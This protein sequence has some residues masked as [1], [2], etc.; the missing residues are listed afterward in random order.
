MVFANSG[1]KWMAVSI[2]RH[3]HHVRQKRFKSNLS[4]KKNQGTANAP[5]HQNY[6]GKRVLCIFEF[7]TLNHLSSGLLLN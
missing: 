6:L 2:F 1:N 3:A 4:G 5:F 7:V